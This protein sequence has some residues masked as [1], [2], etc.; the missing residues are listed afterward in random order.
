LEE[1]YYKRNHEVQNHH[2]GMVL[3]GDHIYM[4][5]GHN[6]GLPLCLQMQ[7]GRVLWGPQ[8]G[9]GTGSAAVLAADGHL[10]F[11]YENAVM[12]LIEATPRGYQLKGAFKIKSKNGK[13]WPHPVIADKK[14]Y[15][16]DQDELHC[17]DVAG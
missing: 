12:A 16:R 1:V 7:T 13:S 6:N 5:H 8:R 4:G 9:A 2:G 11:R 17:Y 14:L 3:I 10:Y 15:L